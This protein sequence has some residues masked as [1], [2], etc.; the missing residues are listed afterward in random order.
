MSETSEISSSA[1]SVARTIVSMPRTVRSGLLD[2]GADRR[3][4]IDPK[5]RLVGRRKELRADQ[6]PHPE[7]AAPPPATGSPTKVTAIEP[8]T[9]R[10]WTERPL[11]QPLIG[12]PRCPRRSAATAGRRGRGAGASPDRR[13]F[14]ARS[15]RRARSGVTVR[16]TRNEANRE[17]E[18]VNVSGMNRSLICP[19]RKTVGT[20]DDDR[21]DRGREDRHRH[22]RAASST[23]R[24]RDVPGMFRCRL[25]FSSSTIESST[26][27]PTARARP[28][29]V[30]TLSV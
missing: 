6:G 28:P 4:Q 29:S 14:R 7:P 8:T 20:K 17:T 12:A 10:R 1:L 27:R 15:T 26:S 19:S 3:L 22:L 21:G 5:L 16:E 30:K 2:P 25:M 11:D 9:S 24:R 18:M 23:A 13:A